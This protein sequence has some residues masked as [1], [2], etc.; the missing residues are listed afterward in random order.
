MVFDVLLM[1][2]VG[3]PLDDAL[4]DSVVDVVVEQ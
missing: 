4:L 3:V 2:M 1:P